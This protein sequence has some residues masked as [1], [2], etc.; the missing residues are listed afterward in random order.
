MFAKYQLLLCFFFPLLLFTFYLLL[1]V[2]LFLLLSFVC[3]CNRRSIDR[4]CCKNY[5]VCEVC[6]N[7]L[8]FLSYSGFNASGIRIRLYRVFETRAENKARQDKER[9]VKLCSAEV[10]QSQKK[11]PFSGHKIEIG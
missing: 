9:Q 10:L 3:F 5:K 4:Y 8:F 6:F 11:P 1:L 7:N 2:L